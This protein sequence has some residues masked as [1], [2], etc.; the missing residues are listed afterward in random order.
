MN[1]MSLGVIGLGFT[2]RIHAKNALLLPGARLA[3]V[4]D[5]DAGQFDLLTEE[6]RALKSDQAI[7]GLEQAERLADADAVIRHEGVDALVLCLPTHLHEAYTLKALK[8]G[9]HVLCE[10]PMALDR[11]QCESM[12]AA[13]NAENR[14]LMVAHC[15][16]FWPE[17][18]FLR[19]CIAAGRF[20]RLL[21]L[22]MWRLSGMPSWS[23]DNWLLDPALS[24]GPLVDLHIHDVD[25]ALFILGLPDRLTSTGRASPAS[26]GLDIVHTFFEYTNGP[27]VHLHAGWST[28]P[29]PFHAGYEAW[30]EKG[31]V[32][33]STSADPSLEIYEQGRDDPLEEKTGTWDAYQEELSYFLGCIRTGTTPEMC[34]SESSRDSLIA[35]LRCVAS[36]REQRA[37][38]R[39]EIL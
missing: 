33:H 30:F 21:S 23:S 38:T 24:G 36:A 28:A 22:N 5:P 18:L 31:F 13:S 37:F 14:R 2:G 25:F 32:K 9:L 15:L 7:K 4:A 17:Y 3:A 8:S 27:Q 6:I 10:K 11:K 26:K 20:G 12:I 39:E 29:I 34:T 16:R 35:V 1:Q 19:D